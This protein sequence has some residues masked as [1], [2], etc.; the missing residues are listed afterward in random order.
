MTSN[1]KLVSANEH[2]NKALGIT[3]IQ[4]LEKA[5]QEFQEQ[6]PNMI[7]VR[8][9]LD[10]LPPK[11]VLFCRYENPI[12]VKGPDAEKFVDYV[13]T[14]TASSCAPGKAR[15]VILCNQVLLF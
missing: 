9:K 5:L 11:I 13:I 15:Y 7:K 12:R 1:T 3:D 6:A 14:R 8:P 10:S 2:L 4:Q